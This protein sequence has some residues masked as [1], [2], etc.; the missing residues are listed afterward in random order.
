MKITGKYGVCAL[1][2]FLAAACGGGGDR[3]GEAGWRGRGLD[4]SFV[5]FKEDRVF[6]ALPEAGDKSP[7]LEFSARLLGAAGALGD[8]ITG[9]LY[10]GLGREEFAAACFGDVK[11]RYEEA[12]PGEGGPETGEALS[13]DWTWLRRDAG[14]VYGSIV[15]LQKYGEYFEGGA[16]PVHEKNYFV[17][18][19]ERQ[20]QV[21][22]KDLVKEGAEEEMASA[23]RELLIRIYAEKNGEEAA[24]PGEMAEAADALSLADLG[25]FEDDVVLP[26]ENF[27]LTEEGIGFCWEEYEIAPYYFGI[28]EIVLPRETAGA[29]LSDEGNRVSD[30]VK[31]HGRP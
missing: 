2:L 3:E 7:A 21:F 20:K 25:F 11:R 31:G 23:A 26:E 1:V 5:V 24:P 28:I 18:D 19:T 27:Y 4:S 14:A 8:F 29:L 10:D 6:R 16:H 12:V 13:F 15:V 30:I 22:F 9:R 17:F